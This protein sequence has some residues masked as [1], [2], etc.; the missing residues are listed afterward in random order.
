MEAIRSGLKKRALKLGKQ[1]TELTEKSAKQTDRT[2]G[3][4][5]NQS[6]EEPTEPDI[7]LDV[8]ETQIS[9][10]SMPPVD[11]IESSPEQLGKAQAMIFRGTGHNRAQT[12]IA[13]QFQPRRSSI[14]IS[15]KQNQSQPLKRR[16]SIAV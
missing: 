8:G 13:S 9:H 14:L 4:T 15:S 3:E 1:N 6:R 2:G 5:T 10:G 16:A 7:I 12:A 11:Q